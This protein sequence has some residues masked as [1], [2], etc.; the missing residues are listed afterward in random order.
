MVRVDWNDVERLARA[1]PRAELF[2]LLEITERTWRRWRVRSHLPRSAWLLLRGF[3]GEL[4]AIGGPAW[5]G[6]R[7]VRG[8]LVDPADVVHTPATIEAWH[9]IRQELQALRGRENREAPA[10]LPANVR[11]LCPR[12]WRPAHALTQRLYDRL[13]GES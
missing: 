1:L 11:V 7:L 3:A 10:T 12:R 13:E 6:W 2:A 4:E 9:W 5:R 8:R